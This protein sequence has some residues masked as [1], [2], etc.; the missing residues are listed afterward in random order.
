[1]IPVIE[2][3]L[4]SA[5]A[6][7]Q[8]LVL[9]VHKHRT[10]TPQY[11]T[12][13]KWI[14]L[15]DGR[16]RMLDYDASG[17]LKTETAASAT[18]SATTR[19]RVI[20]RTLVTLDYESKTWSISTPGFEC[21]SFCTLPP[22]PSGACGCDLDP[23]ANYPGQTARVLLLG[24]ETIDGKPTFH[25]RFTIKGGHNASTTDIWIDRFTYLPVHEKAAFRDTSTKG[26]PIVTTIN[27]FT[28]LPRTHANLAR[29]APIIPRGFTRG[30][31]QP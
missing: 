11:V 14:D 1:M 28:W 7:S 4:G 26:H 2:H 16:T 20:Q 24:Q 10:R 27:E 3:R 17:R 29:L 5:L 22:P 18:R 13:V 8:T 9:R 30:A 19:G 31:T 6:K 15:A 25:L 23:F 21:G 12:A